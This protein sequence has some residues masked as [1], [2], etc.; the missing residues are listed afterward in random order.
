MEVV[1]HV[2][3]GIDPH[4]ATHTAVA[5]GDREDEISG[6]KVRATRDQVAKLLTWSAPFPS[7]L[8][9]VEGAEGL[10]FLLAQ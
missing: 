3:I 5:I 1:M 10:G 4:K 6:L 2:I 8:W 7:R 9:A